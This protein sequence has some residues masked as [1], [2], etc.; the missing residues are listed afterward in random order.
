MHI[1]ELQQQC[2]DLAKEK[3][4]VDETNPVPVPEQVALIC[5]EACEAL[6]SWREHQPTS[7]TGE[8]GK[9]EGLASEYADVVIRI[10]HYAQANGFDLE[11]EIIRKLAYNKTRPHR[12]GGKAA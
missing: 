6:E 5:S 4:W 8:K 2:Y 12:H 10:G 3:G 1:R 7:W 11:E 9:P